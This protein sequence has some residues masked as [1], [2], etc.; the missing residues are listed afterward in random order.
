MTK[1]NQEES[2]KR[3]GLR[4]T[5]GSARDA[6]GGS[7]DRVSGTE[8]RRQLEQFT[9]VVQTTV[10][11]VHRDQQELDKRLQKLEQ[12]T[13]AEPAAP[14]AQGCVVVALVISVVALVISVVAAILALVALLVA[15]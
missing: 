12:P 10:V 9:D 14:P 11:G 13:P 8:Y 5:L 6:I 4:G 3:K 2:A 1:E 7:L 15:K